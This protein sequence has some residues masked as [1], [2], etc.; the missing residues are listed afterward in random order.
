M[1]SLSGKNTQAGKKKRL[2]KIGAAEAGPTSRSKGRRVAPPRL[3]LVALTGH[4]LHGNRWAAAAAWGAS[5]WPGAEGH[6]MREDGTESN[7]GEIQVLFIIAIV[8]ALAYLFH[9]YL[10]KGRNNGGCARIIAFVAMFCPTAA[11]DVVIRAERLA[12][13]TATVKSIVGMARHLSLTETLLAFLLLKDLIVLLSWTVRKLSCKGLCRRTVKNAQAL[14]EPELFFSP[15]GDC[16]H[17]DRSCQGLLRATRVTGRKRC[18]YCTDRPTL[19]NDGATW[20]ITPKP[21]MG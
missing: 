7:L 14:Q 13:A 19:S 5:Q 21:K 6:V 9:Y 10:N 3:P 4:S 16:W 2:G 20:H 8:V 18:L 17:V 1:R 15:H 11:G 12:D